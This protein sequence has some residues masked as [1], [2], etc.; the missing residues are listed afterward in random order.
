MTLSS[1]NILKSFAEQNFFSFDLDFRIQNSSGISSVG[2]SGEFGAVN[3]FSF[4]SGKI[5]DG[6]NRFVSTY[7][8]SEQ[9]KISGNFR[10][11][12]FGY[13]INNIPICLNSQLTS[14]AFTFDNFVFSTTGTDIDC[15]MNVFGERN[16]DYELFFPSNPQLTGASIT[17]YIKNNSSSFFQSFKVFS[18]SGYFPDYAYTLTSNLSGLKLKPNRSGELVLSFAGNGEFPVDELKQVYPLNGDLYFWTNFG[19]FSVPISVPL[20][21]SPSY[22]LNF[23]QVENTRFGETGTLWSFNIE[24]QACSGTRFEFLF[25]DIKW[26]D[27]YYAFSN[28]FQIKTGYNNTGFA[29]SLMLY[30]AARGAYIGTGFIPSSGCFSNDTFDTRFEIFYSHPS[31]IFP[32]WFRYSFSGIDEN[33]LFTGIIQ[34]VT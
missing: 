11:G 12:V 17:G 6:L 23:E 5:F 29:S 20:K 4:S 18:G 27:P 19:N 22:S 2:I 14:S 8:P 28:S 24:R 15:L 10:S 21:A 32:N 7:S 9:M 34:Q 30:S 1:G 16:P 26:F 25:D 3:L 13:Y 33:F 31:G